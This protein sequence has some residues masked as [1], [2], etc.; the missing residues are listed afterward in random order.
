VDVLGLICNQVNFPSRLNDYGYEYGYYYHYAYANSGSY[1]T[2][3]GTYGTN[4]ARK[5]ARNLTRTPN[6]DSPVR[7]YHEEGAAREALDNNIP[8]PGTSVEPKAIP[9]D[10][11]TSRNGSQSGK[12]AD[13]AK[14]F[15]SFIGRLLS[16]L[17]FRR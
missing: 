16:K 10:R 11:P 2:A 7:R 1:A 12:E 5:L 4:M 15:T 17:P 3:Y 14:G 9:N 8:S 13:S 6:S